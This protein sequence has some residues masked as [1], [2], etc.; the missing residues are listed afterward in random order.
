MAKIQLGEIGS[1]LKVRK[2]YMKT[3]NQLPDVTR[4]NIASIAQ[5]E[6][7]TH[8]NRTL[9]ERM[10][11]D[12]AAFVG[13]WTFIIGLSSFLFAWMVLNV[14]AW[15]HHWDPY[16]FILLNL[17]LSFQTAFV[18]PILMMSQNRQARLMERRNHLDLQINLLAEQE[19]TEMLRLLRQLCTRAGIL[20][21]HTPELQGLEENTEPA[22]LVREIE[23]ITNQAKQNLKSDKPA[24]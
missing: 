6:A 3:E 12:F 20:L 10:S 8:H 17:V 16:P 11:D 19:N 15:A 23:K 7:D 1:F 13:S 9:G 18:C 2:K 22:A 4:K 24:S 14:I 21:D 5:M